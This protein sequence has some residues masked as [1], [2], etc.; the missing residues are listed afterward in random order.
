MSVPAWDDDNSI[1][2]GRRRALV[3]SRAV[4]PDRFAVLL[5]D[6]PEQTAALKHALAGRPV[7][8]ETANDPA[9]GL[10]LLGRTC[11]DVAVVGPTN[12]SQPNLGQ[13]PVC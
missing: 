3:G 6:R 11:P 1:L 12:G 8:L 13:T 2:H 7:E 10:F 9:V 4:K 5:V